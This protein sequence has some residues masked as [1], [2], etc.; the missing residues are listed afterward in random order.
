[1]VRL[2][3]LAALHGHPLR[4]WCLTREFCHSFLV[5]GCERMIHLRAHVLLLE[6]W[7]FSRASCE[8]GGNAKLCWSTS[9]GAPHTQHLRPITWS[10][11]STSARTLP[12][13]RMLTWTLTR[14]GWVGLS[15]AFSRRL[16]KVSPRS[17]F[18]FCVCR[19]CDEWSVGGDGHGA[20]RVPSVLLWPC[21]AFFAAQGFEL[22][23]RQV[24][25]KSNQG[26]SRTGLGAMAEGS[27]WD[28]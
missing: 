15:F 14:T 24:Q 25:P 21:R 18:C 3:S 4:I 12:R 28:V 27:V 16:L 2:K 19:H 8:M 9:V 5:L 11:S 6:R 23:R 10:C 20:P 13:S 17:V 22:N 26:S 1:M 7:H